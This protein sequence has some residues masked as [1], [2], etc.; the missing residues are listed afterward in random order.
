VI[1]LRAFR[2]VSGTTII[3]AA[4]FVESA[5]PVCATDEPPP[6]EQ[7]KGE[8]K[9]A[10]TGP[11]SE[12]SA[13]LVAPTSLPVI[14][15]VPPAGSPSSPAARLSSDSIEKKRLADP[16]WLLHAM[17]AQA[18]AKSGQQHRTG[19]PEVNLPD[20]Q[21][22]ETD[23]HDSKNP[24]SMLKIYREQE[25]KDREQRDGPA[26]ATDVPVS[27]PGDV[28]PFSDLLKQW[29]S[30]RDSVLLGLEPGSASADPGAEMQAAVPMPRT[31]AGMPASP[32]GPNPFLESIQLESRVPDMPAVASLPPGG[33]LDAPRDVTAPPV[34]SPPA[35]GNETPSAPAS[36]QADEKKYFPQLDR[37]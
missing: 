28:G 26:A 19:T 14:E 35:L 21:Q 30:P 3:A 22:A 34:F 5:A 12:L 4:L 8:L 6:I 25:L 32:Q 29:I 13:P 37:F 7:I 9:A 23:Q 2:L 36:R 31:P 16:D 17:E 10:K 11:A 27:K 24:D 1:G 20:A 15:I 18:K 33:L